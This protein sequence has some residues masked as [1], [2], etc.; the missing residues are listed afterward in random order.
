V[1]GDNTLEDP[2]NKVKM[3]EAEFKRLMF[4]E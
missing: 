2:F 3:I 1:N 4:E